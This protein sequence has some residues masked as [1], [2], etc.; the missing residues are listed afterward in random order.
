V[1]FAFVVLFKA[2]FKD[3]FYIYLT[4]VSGF[5]CFDF[6]Y[7]FFHNIYI[8]AFF[9][10]LTVGIAAS[11]Y[12]RTFKL[13]AATL[14]LPGIILLVPGSMG[15]KGLSSLIEKNTLDGINTLVDVFMTGIFLVAGLLLANILIPPKRNL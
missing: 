3:A 2:R 8:S 10:A 12:A 9:S 4:L 15:F 1:P 11:L 7:N 14:L 5:S 6:S 13:P